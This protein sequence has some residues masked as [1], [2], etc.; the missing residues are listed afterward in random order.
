[1]VVRKAVWL[2]VMMLAFGVNAAPAVGSE[3]APHFGIHVGGDSIVYKEMSD[4]GG[5]KDTGLNYALGVRYDNVLTSDGDAFHSLEAEYY[6]GKVK[7]KDIN[8]DEMDD[9]KYSGFR[10]EGL[11]GTR[12]GNNLGVDLIG[13]ALVD[14]GKRREDTDTDPW[15]EKQ[16][17]IAARLGLGFYHRVGAF[18][19]RVTGG[20]NYPFYAKFRESNY[21]A[22]EFAF[23]TSGAVSPFVKAYVNFGVGGTKAVQIDLYYD[24]LRFKESSEIEAIG[25]PWPEKKYSR[26]GGRVAFYF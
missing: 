9:V 24:T 17:V 21:T 22:D 3:S 15:T 19:Y 16:R 25:I 18:R 13:G 2:G 1:M 23:S 5:R 14:Y 20:V 12:I 7:S 11:G 10:L 4:I 26:I 8:G 6:S